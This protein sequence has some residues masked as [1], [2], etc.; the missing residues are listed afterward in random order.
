MTR[1]ACLSLHH[2]LLAAAATISRLRDV[3]RAIV[4]DV[5]LACHSLVLETGLMITLL[6]YISC[7]R[8]E[9]PCLWNC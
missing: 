3:S 9:E 6:L 5:R 2:Q 8:V 7:A 1:A 4:E